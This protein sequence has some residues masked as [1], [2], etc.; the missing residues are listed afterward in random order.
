MKKKHWEDYTHL[1][2]RRVDTAASA[3]TNKVLHFVDQA[4]FLF[5]FLPV[6]EDIFSFHS[7]KSYPSLLMQTTV[8]NLSTRAAV[9]TK[10]ITVFFFSDLHSKPVMSFLLWGKS[11][12]SPEDLLKPLLILQ[13][14]D[15][16]AG[17]FSST[18]YICLCVHIF[19]ESAI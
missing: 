5:F 7:I 11:D 6:L 15:A 18:P 9:Q 19:L 10:G 12:E 3:L 1:F 2:Q 8:R 4:R 17:S 13:G 14:L 16:D